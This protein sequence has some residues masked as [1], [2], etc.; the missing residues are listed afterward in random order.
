V[1]AVREVRNRYMV[2]PKTPL[3]VA[4]RCSLTVASDFE[5]LTP[6]IKSM[7][8]V[9]VLVFGPD[10][11]KLPQSATHVHPDFEAYMSLH[12]LIDVA[13][14]TTRLEKQIAEKKKSLA[15]TQG[16]LANKS[17]V[18]R[19]P[20]DVVQQQR[21]QVVELESQIRALEENLRDLS[22]GE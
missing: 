1:R 20:P 3:D 7:A 10:V 4:V 8:G 14:E 22:T 16:K 15:G 21:E 2:E 19:A 5:A 6:F 17:F 9:G 11:R 13:K 12:G 18:D